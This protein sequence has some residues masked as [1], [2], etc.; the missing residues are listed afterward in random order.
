MP[1]VA[2]LG[3]LDTKGREY[4]FLRDRVREAGCGTL[5]IDA[6]VI[7]E[8]AFA[9]DI[10]RAALFAAGGFDAAAL[11]AK[12]DR[13]EAVT[14]AA[15]SAEVLIRRL[16][17]EG[18]IHGVAALGGSA[19]TT[20]ATAAMRALPVGVPKL[21]VSTLASGD[22]RP[23]VGIRDVCMMYSVV[24]IAGINRLS[25]AILTNAAGAI[26]GMVLTQG[27]GVRG[28]GSGQN[29]GN[30]Q[31]A[32]AG[33]PVPLPLSPPPSADRPLI[34]MTM[35]GV[36]TP[37]VSAAQKILEDAGG[38]CLVFHATGTGGRAMESLIDDGFLT[39]VCDVTTT[40]WADELVGGV[41]SAGPTRLDAAGRRGIPQVVGVGALDMVNFGPRDTVP[42][43]FAGRL[44]YQHNATVTLMR[45]TVDE[46]RRLGEIIAGKLNAAR[47]PVKLFLPLRGLSAIDAEGKPFHDPAA[48]GALYDALER[49]LDRRRVELIK[50]DNHINDPEFAEAMAGGLLALMKR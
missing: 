6:A 36:T 12:G 29:V 35:F 33:V 34:G 45:T 19:G 42:A 8:P 5:V 14:A 9:P 26:A 37:C 50:L 23:Y 15:K 30:P 4:A 48:R 46:N 1:T 10:D 47:G 22:T 21:M 7:G 20:I 11:K 25:R 18:G 32:I 13:G 43:K 16:Y 31:T 41:L 39:A 17:D 24:D 40:E 27:T 3:T 44:F 28:L 38:E 49:N 2:L